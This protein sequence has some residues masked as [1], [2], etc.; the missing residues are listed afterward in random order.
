M[1]ASLMK[2]THGLRRRRGETTTVRA[3]S[4]LTDR[5]LEDIGVPRGLIA[6]AARNAG[7]NRAHAAR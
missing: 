4:A 5:Q 3:L 6:E 7:G 1:I 2:L